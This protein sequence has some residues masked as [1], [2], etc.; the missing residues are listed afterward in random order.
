MKFEENKFSQPGFVMHFETSY[1][2]EMNGFHLGPA[3]EIA[4]DAE[5][6]HISTGIH[7]GIEF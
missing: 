2:F 7:I 4:G 6:F 1:E 5:D 3:L